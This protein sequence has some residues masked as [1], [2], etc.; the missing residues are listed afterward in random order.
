VRA[1]S[2]FSVLEPAKDI[3]VVNDSIARNKIDASPSIVAAGD[4]GLRLE[5]QLCF[6]LYAASRAVQQLYQPLLKPLGL[7]YPQY[8]VLLVLWE[9]D[10]AGESPSVGEVGER[11][12]LDSGTLTPLLR[13]LEASGVLRRERSSEDERVVRV[14]LTA[15]GRRLRRTVRSVPHALFCRAGLTPDEYLKLLPEIDALYKRLRARAEQSEAPSEDE[16][17]RT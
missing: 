11:L 7:T 13:R 12:F 3:S 15:E 8:L 16:T 14:S 17:P 6:R 4:D 1:S 10:E 2:G 5:S 9:M